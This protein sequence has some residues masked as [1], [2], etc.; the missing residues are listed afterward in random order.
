MCYSQGQICF[1]RYTDY[2]LNH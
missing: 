1:K 2:N